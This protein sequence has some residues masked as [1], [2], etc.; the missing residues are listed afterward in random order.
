MDRDAARQVRSGTQAGRPSATDLI[1]FLDESN[2]PMRH[3]ASGLVDHSG[4]F[5]VIAGVVVLRADTDELRAEM[6]L[7]VRRLGMP[8]HYG[9]IRSQARR[10][11]LVDLVDGLTW[12][13][14]HVFETAHPASARHTSEHFV[15]ARL[16]KVALVQLT[17]AGGVTGVTLETRSSPSRGLDQID[18]RDR[19]VIQR[20]QD[21][22]LV[23]PGV[24]MTHADKSEPLLWL[25]DVLAGARSD[26]ICAVDP[27]ASARLAHRMRIVRVE[28]GR[29]R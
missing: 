8:V 3:R 23:S 10:R 26:D 1:A 24:D 20:L 28:V 11:A 21:Q 9:R 15:R 29:R 18:L 16:L 25:A 2:K 19:S 17:G 14:A 7:I 4:D 27:G 12:W 22:G 6:R 13:E 5:Y